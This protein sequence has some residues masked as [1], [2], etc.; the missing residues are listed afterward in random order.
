MVSFAEI[1][2]SEHLGFRLTGLLSIF[3]ESVMLFVVCRCSLT[4]LTFCILL[5]N[6][7]KGNTSW[8][9][10]CSLPIHFSWMS[11]ARDASALPP[12]S[13]TPRLWCYA[14]AAPRFFASPRVEEPVWLRVARS[15]RREINLNME[16]EV[17]VFDFPAY[18][19]ELK[20]FVCGSVD[21]FS[22]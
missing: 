2:R 7:R 12:F 16:A 6:W 18:W 13:V 5:R 20:A 22:L 19:W 4:I 1:D 17:D 15:G 3:W 14:A 9:G 11:N 8:K 10:L 21:R